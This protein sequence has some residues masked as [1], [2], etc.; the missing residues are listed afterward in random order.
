M[1]SSIIIFY[2]SFVLYCDS[3]FQYYESPSKVFFSVLSD[4]DISVETHYAAPLAWRNILL[5]IP[6]SFAWSY[7]STYSYNHWLLGTQGRRW[8]Y[9][10]FFTS[11]INWKYCFGGRQLDDYYIVQ[12]LT[13]ITTM[14][15]GYY[16]QLSRKC[17]I[18]T[19]FV[20]A[21]KPSIFLS[22]GC[23]YNIYIPISCTLI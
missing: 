14:I 6:F 18:K 20:S 11:Q 5:C 17:L 10:S 19:Q 8:C 16:V 13:A 7:V 9:Y 3:L 21:W 22:L 12:H 1:R 23:F 2:R 15:I 4:D